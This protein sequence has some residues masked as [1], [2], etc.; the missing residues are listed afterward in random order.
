IMP[1]AIAISLPLFPAGRR[2]TAI[3]FMSSLS[4]GA[5]AIGPT[6][7]AALV[8]SAGWRWV[9]YI[10]LPVVAAV[11][12]LARRRLPDVPGR[13]GEPFDT[14]GVPLGA[15]AIALA[16]LALSHGPE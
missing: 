7:G 2:S 11:L 13:P 3:A 5:S 1:S 12:V 16:V 14:I 9:F 4:S 10:N 15:L 8:D 6:A